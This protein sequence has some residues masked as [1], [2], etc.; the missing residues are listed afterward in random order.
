MRV[1]AL[2][3]A[4]VCLAMIGVASAGIPSA[5]TSTV[6]RIAE[7]RPGCD[8]DVGVVCPASDMGWI[9]VTVT[10]RNIYGDPLPGKIV[11]CYAIWSDP[12]Y[13]FCFCPGETPQT[14]TT[15]DY[16]VVV[17]YFSDFGG[18]GDIQFGAECE[19]VVFDPCPLIYVAS[20]DSNGD[21]QVNVVDFGNF[22]SSYY[23]TDPC[24]D[25]NCDGIVDVIDFGIFASHYFHMC[26]P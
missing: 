2:T 11:D 20:P 14:D 4:I 21:C 5:S 26:P 13:T 12:P 19:G 25:F 1:F 7:G 18:C 6:E 3:T 23:T 9:K 24:C 10:V 22:A 8:P 15:D 17:F 16:G